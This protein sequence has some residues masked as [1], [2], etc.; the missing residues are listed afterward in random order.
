[1]KITSYFIKHPVSSIILN[2]AIILI[3]IL[4]FYS[5]VVREYPEVI[6]PKLTVVASYPNASAELVESSVTN[7]LEDELAG[8]EGVDSMSSD[9]AYGARKYLNR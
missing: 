5:L 8:V 4:S 2:A 6:L 1:M 7:V 3:G 9:S